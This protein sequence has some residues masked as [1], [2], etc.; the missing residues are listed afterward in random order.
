MSCFLVL[1]VGSTPG[2]PVEKI[3]IQGTSLPFELAD[4]FSLGSD[5]V[6][7]SSALLRT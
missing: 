3:L 4:F 7:P 6:V 5:I 1:D 2:A